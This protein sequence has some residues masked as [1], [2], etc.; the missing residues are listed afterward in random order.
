VT[1]ALGE[2]PEGLVDALQPALPIRAAARRLELLTYDEDG[3]WVPRRGF[4]LGNREATA[5]G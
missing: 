4:Q 5:L 2:E 1:V 3:V